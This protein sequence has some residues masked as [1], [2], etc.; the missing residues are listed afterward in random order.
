M[1]ILVGLL[2]IGFGFLLTFLGFKLFRILLPIWGLIAGAILGFTGTT[3]LLAN[4]PGVNI[5]AIIVAIVMALVLAGLAYFFY[6]IAILIF[7]ASLGYGLSV[8]LINAIGI[9]FA[10]TNLLVGIT[11]AIIFGMITYAYNVRKYFIVLVTATGGA[12]L[13]IVGLFV[14]LG[15]APTEYVFYSRFAREYIADGFLWWVV[16]GV[17]SIL[18]IVEQSL[19]FKIDSIEKYSYDNAEA[20]D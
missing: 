9:D 6:S 8:L 1:Q 2:A 7:A 3:E 17:I 16:F 4:V 15:R 10:I 19:P 13:M 18:G 20:L 11:G 5:M 14:L 12:S